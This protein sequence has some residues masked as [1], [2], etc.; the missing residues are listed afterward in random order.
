LKAKKTKTSKKAAPDRELLVRAL[1]YAN[2]P[3]HG[4]KVADACKKYGITLS[5]YKRARRDF[6]DERRLSS[7]DEIILAGL[8]PKGATT[9]ERLIFY[10][11]WIN[12]AGLTRD[13]VLAICLR[14]EARGLVR[15]VD[16]ER[17]ELIA[18][19]P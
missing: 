2:M 1:K 18:D 15:R 19:W 10:Y 12:H 9:L 13:E 7:D 6:G 14:L 16:E 4:Y 3:G 5:A 11:D 17:F 8:H